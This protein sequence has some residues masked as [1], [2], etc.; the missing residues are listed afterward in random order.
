M[1]AYTPHPALSRQ[2]VPA[3]LCQLVRDY[4]GKLPAHDGCIVEEKKD[5]WRALWIDGELVTREGTPIHGCDHIVAQLQ[6]LE[7]KLCRPTF[8]DGELIVGDSFAE[9]HAHLRCGGLRGDQ[10]TFWMWDMLDMD[11]WHGKAVCEPL[12]ARRRRLEDLAGELTGEGARVLPWL[13]FIDREDIEAHAAQVI[14]D[15]GE[16]III[17]DPGAVYTRRRTGAWQRIKRE[18]PAER[19]GRW[20]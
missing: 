19:G 1:N 6:E 16:G 10:G 20:K 3:Q 17:K 4:A 5:G 9:T 14:A 8:F 12:T 11:T 7:R 2:A 13:Y 15:G 18:M